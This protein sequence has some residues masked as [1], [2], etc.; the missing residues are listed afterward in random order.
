VALA[1]AAPG[2]AFMIA[3]IVFAAATAYGAYVAPDGRT[4][5]Q[6]V[7]AHVLPDDAHPGVLNPAV[8]ND[9]LKTTICKAGW[10]ATV[11]PPTSYTNKLKRAALPDGAKMADGELD[12]RVSLEVGGDPSA[13]GNLWFQTY[14]DRYGA[15]LKDRLETAVAHR[16]CAGTMTLDEGRNALLGNWL[17]AYERIIGPLPK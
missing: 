9:T 8:G 14:S 16:I 4:A 1:K 12:H 13:P 11:R 17:S 7:A 2:E 5:A 10:T 6:L 15:R 3:V